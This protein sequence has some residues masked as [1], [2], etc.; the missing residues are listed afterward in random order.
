MT[1]APP[2]STVVNRPTF[3][4][5]AAIPSRYTWSSTAGRASGRPACSARMGA[6]RAW[7]SPTRSAAAARAADSSRSCSRFGG[8]GDAGRF[9]PGAGDA[10]LGQLARHQHT[11]ERDLGRGRQGGLDIDPR[12]RHTKWGVGGGQGGQ[13]AVHGRRQVPAHSLAPGFQR[14]GPGRVGSR[15]G[16]GDQHVIQGASRGHAHG[17]SGEETPQRRLNMRLREVEGGG[18]R[19][20]IGDRGPQQHDAAIAGQVAAGALGDRAVAGGGEDVFQPGPLRCRLRLHHQQPLRPRHECH[21]PGWARP[22]RDQA[23]RLHAGDAAESQHHRLAVR[24]HLAPVRRRPG[25]RQDGHGGIQHPERDADGLGNGSVGLVAAVRRH[26]PAAGAAG[27]AAG[28]PG[29]CTRM[30][31]G[32]ASVRR[33]MRVVGPTMLF[34][35]SME[36]TSAYSPGSAW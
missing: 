23:R 24:W 9:R 21:L 33:T 2:G 17:G 6:V 34:S 19:H 14:G 20:L 35:V 18:V 4:S 36:R 28:A 5:S 26:G 16:L 29:P 11:V 22:G 25:H 30:L 7:A 32:A 27:M 8:L 10:L 3:G 15:V 12:H 1:R 13:P 31:N